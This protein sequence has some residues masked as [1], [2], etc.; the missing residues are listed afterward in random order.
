MSDRFLLTFSECCCRKIGANAQQFQSPACVI[1][2]RLG[3][4]YSLSILIQWLGLPQMRKNAIDVGKRN[5]RRYTRLN[6]IGPQICLTNAPDLASETSD[7]AYANPQVPSRL[8]NSILDR[9]YPYSLK[10]A[11][12]S[13]LIVSAC[14]AGMPS[15]K[16]LQVFREFRSFT[17]SRTAARRRHSERSGRLAVHHRHRNSDLLEFRLQINMPRNGKIT[18]DCKR[19]SSGKAARSKHG[20]AFRTVQ[21]RKNRGSG[22]FSFA[23]F[24]KYPLYFL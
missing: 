18:A 19:L 10:N 20:N 15:G 12:R 16:S 4:R 17:A 1:G 23:S 24:R 9:Q 3:S 6:P 11:N 22:P 21:E 8:P 13:A 7:G 14:I 2:H 5:R